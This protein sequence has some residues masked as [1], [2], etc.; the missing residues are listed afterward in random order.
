MRLEAS[1]EESTAILAAMRDV[2]EAGSALTERDRVT[3]VS[4]GR[5]MLGLDEADVDSL[6]S[7]TPGILA[8]ALPEAAL[9]QEAT[10]FL[11][12]MPFV[13]GALDKA[14][15]A[16][17]EDYAHTLGVADGYLDEIAEAAAGDLHGALAHMVRDNMDS[18]L[19]KPFSGDVMAWMLPYQGDKADPALA[20]RFRALSAK[21]EGSFG[22]A[23]ITFY[24]TN[25]YGVP[26]EPTALN[27]TFCLP[28][29][30]TH[31][32]SGYDT[33]P[34]G[35]LL[36]STFTAGMHPRYPV[37]GHILPV[38]FSWHLGIKINDVAKSA[39]GALDP[40]E[41][42]HAWERGQ[43]MRIDIFGPAWDFWAWV[44]QPLAE[45]RTRYL[46]E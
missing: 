28:H 20:S 31:V 16:R 15:I 32:F 33:T 45:L 23:F 22:R 19:G 37:S 12:I 34:R 25:G 8:T 29:D 14:K 7:S 44:D 2:A 42:W 11:A 3:L 6:P 35:E 21:P 40:K 17:V 4:A 41:F 46:P 9:R 1:T 30:S 39:T 24:E 10:R 26:G 43:A 36:V 27:A 13:D 5:W 18:I 38:I